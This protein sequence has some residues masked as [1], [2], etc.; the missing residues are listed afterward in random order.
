[1]IFTNATEYAIRGL[2]ELSG[3]STGGNMLLDQLVQGRAADARRRPQDGDRVGKARFHHP[4]SVPP[5]AIYDKAADGSK[6]IYV[7]IET[8]L[9]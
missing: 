3:R 4:Q 8:K 6:F 2:A 5:P 1:M 9:R 7:S